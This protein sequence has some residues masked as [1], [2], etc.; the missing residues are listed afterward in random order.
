MGGLGSKVRTSQG[1]FDGRLSLGGLTLNCVHS[2]Q[3]PPTKH[4]L[5]CGPQYGI[6]KKVQR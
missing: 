3:L 6:E 1:S 5:V 2:N 4:V